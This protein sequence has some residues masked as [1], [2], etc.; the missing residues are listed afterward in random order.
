MSARTFILALLGTASVSLY[1]QVLETPAPA[2]APRE[3]AQTTR[4][5][6]EKD[7]SPASLIPG[8]EGIFFDPATETVRW[9]GRTWNV[10]NNRAFQARFEKYLNAPEQTSEEERTYQKTLEAIQYYLE[11]AQRHDVDVDKAF[12]FLTKASDFDIDANLCDALAHAVYS[13]WLSRNAENRLLRAN[14][15]LE[16]EVDKNSRQLAWEAQTDLSQLRFTSPPGNESAKKEW[17]EQ[18]KVLREARL[19]PRQIRLAELRAMLEANKVKHAV[20]ELKSK[21]EFQALI[22]QFF[23]QRRFQHVLLGTAFYRHVFSDGRSELELQGEAKN[24]FS[25]ASGLP[26]TLSTLEAMAS[27][28]MRDAREGVRAYTFLLEENELESATKRLAESFIVGEYL[29]ELRRL[30]RKDKREALLFTR[31]ANQLLSAL[32]VKDYTLAE[33]I[34]NELR[35]EA[36]DFDYAMPMAAIETARTVSSMHLARAKN[37]AV[38]GDEETVRTELEA[39]T[40]IWP[41]NPDLA[42]VAQLLFKRADTQQQALAD[43]DRLFSQGNYRQIYEDRARFIAAVTLSPD[44]QDQLQ[45]VLQNMQTVE[46]SII[47]SE[48]TVKRGDYAGAWEAV[49]KAYREFPNDNKLNQVRADLTT[50]APDFVRAVMNAQHLEEKGQL[51]SS[52]AWYLKAQRLYPV[53]EF[54]RAGIDRLAKVILEGGEPDEAIDSG[55]E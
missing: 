25:S 55:R 35:V 8:Q 29:P 33:T 48:E 28:A 54:A 52:L 44:R 45:E 40:E 30:S 23:M 14:E 9:D 2:P 1:A 21:V 20:S 41:R 50:R 27:E 47:R 42:E 15:T 22:L 24:L 4:V 43:L 6:K 39:A 49:E 16:S 17:L 37:A 34:V 10:N 32:D 5:V 38:S 31:K 18:R 13:A 3:P 11:P 19:T 51:A 12:T 26:P 46:A 53:S 36:K 7:A